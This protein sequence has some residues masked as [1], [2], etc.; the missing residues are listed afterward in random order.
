MRAMKAIDWNELNALRNNLQ[1]LIGNSSDKQRLLN[2]FSNLAFESMNSK[3][4]SQHSSCGWLD[5]KHIN[6]QK[7]MHCKSPVNFKRSNVYIKWKRLFADK[8]NV[9]IDQIL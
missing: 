9:S 4:F 3:F 5:V 1:K 2:L 7:K 6:S 8:P